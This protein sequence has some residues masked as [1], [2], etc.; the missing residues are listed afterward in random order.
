[1]EMWLKKHISEDA[2]VAM[3]VANQAIEALKAGHVD[4]VVIDSFQA[5]AFSKKNPSL[6]Y[7]VIAQSDNGYGVAVQKNSELKDQI[8]RALGVLKE[9]GEIAVLQKKWLGNK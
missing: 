2:I 9:K 5:A 7:M 4:G 3:D 8:N 1:M 6:S